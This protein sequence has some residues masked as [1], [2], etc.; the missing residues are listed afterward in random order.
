M[1]KKKDCS[2]DYKILKARLK[3]KIKKNQ[4]QLNMKNSQNYLNMNQ[5][6]LIKSLKTFVPLKD[7]LDFIFKK[8][9]SNFNR[10]GKKVLIKLAKD[11]NKI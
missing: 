11:E 3:A 5:L 6:W 2:K 7:E 4:N 9:G 1:I 10:T 8:F